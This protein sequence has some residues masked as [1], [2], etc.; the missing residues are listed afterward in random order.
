MNL[1]LNPNCMA[2][3]T[4][5]SEQY[6]LVD[7]EQYNIEYHWKALLSSFQLNGHTLGFPP[8]TQTL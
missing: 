3:Q 1:A 2:I 4:T 7:F 6:F 5:A 8:K